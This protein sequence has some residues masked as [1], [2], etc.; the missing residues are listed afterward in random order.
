MQAT[1]LREEHRGLSLFLALGMHLLIGVLLYFG[2][3][4]QT[5][6]AAPVEVELWAG[7]LEP[8]PAP[9]PEAVKPPP[10]R[11]PE[12]EPE[13]ELAPPQLEPEIEEERPKPVKPEKPKP[14]PKPEPK[15]TPRPEPPKKV[16]PT[17]KPEPKPTPVKQPAKAEVGQGKQASDK[18]GKLERPPLDASASLAALAARQQA[19]EAAANAKAFEAYLG[20][21]RNKIRRNMTYPDDGADNPSVQIRVTLLPDM[22]ILRAEVVRPSA[23]AAFDQAVEKAV[24]RTGQYPP[25]PPGVDFGSIRQNTFTYRL[26]DAN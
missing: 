11:E 19:A 12:V 2:V 20:L 23:N 18:A 17:R 10:P 25:L 24:M 5:R 16:E 4:W 21:V 22:S 7:A 3:Q 1:A 26:R 9:E 8:A 6:P 15:P 13:P 14:T